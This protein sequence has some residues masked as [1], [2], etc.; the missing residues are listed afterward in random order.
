[1]MRLNEIAKICNMHSSGILYRAKVLDIQHIKT[2]GGTFFEHNDTKKII[3]YKPLKRHLSRYTIY[4]IHKTIDNK[5][6]IIT[7]FL[8][9][10]KNSTEVISKKLEISYSFTCRVISDFLEN[11]GFLIIESKIN[12]EP[13]K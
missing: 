7:C 8:S 3:N 12:Y 1:M 10:N 5:F 6:R 2:I 11:K 13:I 9:D 4:P